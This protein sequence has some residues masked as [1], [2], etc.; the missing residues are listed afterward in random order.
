LAG[1]LGRPFYVVA[2][3]RNEREPEAL[4]HLERVEAAGYSAGDPKGVG[5]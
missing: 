2:R 5:L 1:G 4:T 3:A